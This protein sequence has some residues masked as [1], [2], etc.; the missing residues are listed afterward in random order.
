MKFKYEYPIYQTLQRGDILSFQI[1]DALIEHF[2]LEQCV[3]D[4][5]PSAFSAYKELK[6]DGRFYITDA[7][8]DAVEKS[9]GKLRDLINADSFSLEEVIFMQGRLFLHRNGFVMHRV[10]TKNG[11]SFFEFY[12]FSKIALVGWGRIDCNNAASTIEGVENNT[13]GYLATLQPVNP[14]SIFIQFW[15][16]YLM[17]NIFLSECEVEIKVVQPDGKFKYEKIKYFNDLKSPITFLDCRWFRELIIDA[18]F[19]VSGHL[20]WQPCGEGRSKKKL[21]WIAPFEKKGYHR[22]PKAEHLQ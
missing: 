12:I 22:K 4:I 17:F 9:T 21:I 5:A 2:G 8:A 11:K 1:D 14:R 20:R 15:A 10:T 13:D 3:S 16:S 6:D 19:G 18:P 7:F